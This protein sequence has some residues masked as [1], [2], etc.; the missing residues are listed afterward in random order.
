MAKASINKLDAAGERLVRIELARRNFWE[1]CKLR[2]PA[3]YN[4][5]RP[6]LK[7]MCTT[8]QLFFEQDEK[9]I[10]VLNLPPRHYKSLTAQL[11]TEWTFGR[12]R[13]ARVM[14]GSYNEVLAT[15]FSKKTR[16]AIQTPTGQS[17]KIQYGDI[18]PDTKVSKKDAAAESWALV[19]AR[20]APSYL[21]TSPGGTAVGMGCTLMIFDDIIRSPKEAYSDSVLE[22]LSA[23]VFDTM[24][25]RLEGDWKIIV[26]MQRW[27]LKDIAGQFLAEYDCMHV[28]YPAYSVDKDGK[29]TFLCPEQLDE[30]SWRAKTRLMSPHVE[31]AIYLQKPVDIA[32]RLYNEFN[33]YPVRDI[34]PGKEECVYSVTDTADKGKDYLCSYVYIL[35]DGTAYILDHVLSD[36]Q[37]EITEVQVAEMFDKWAVKIAFTES[38]NG[39]RLFARNVRR[40]M[41]RKDC[42]FLSEMTTTNKEARILL[43]AG[44]CQNYVWF[45]EPWKHSWSPL[46]DQIMSYNAKGKNVHDDAVDCMSFVF[47]R[48]TQQVEVTQTDY[49]GDSAFAFSSYRE[50]SNPYGQ[51]TYQT[52]WNWA[53]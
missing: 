27:S 6:W 39:G 30:A 37:M 21:A 33:T 11:F 7:D 10:L 12:D 15:R 3:V 31:Q 40:L 20:D 8:M 46:Y 13:N 47:D 44:W 48:C 42:V 38:N 25:S 50:D 17:K 22:D 4:E 29:M 49:D 2:I 1:Y 16:N 18:F 41:R 51:K 9:R 43:S 19:G 52:Y 28:D 34:V 5:K 23:W 45:P 35:R 26:V 32:G 14:T 53:E 36:A 24:M